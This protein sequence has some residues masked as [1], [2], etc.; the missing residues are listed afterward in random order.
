[1]TAPAV[2]EAR[3]FTTA[4]VVEAT[5][6]NHRQLSAR[7]HQWAAV[8]EI[9]CRQG[10]RP[11]RFK[12][13]GVEA[14]VRNNGDGTRTIWARYIGPTPSPTRPVTPTPPTHRPGRGHHT[15]VRCCGLPE[16]LHADAP[17]G[18]DRDLAS[19]G[20]AATHAGSHPSKATA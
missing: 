3:T 1:V 15:G 13:L 19:G 5:G 20:S 18:V 10:L 11:D 2:T 8:A 9:D 14:T 16:V 6:L 12:A 7:P 17:S 4:Q